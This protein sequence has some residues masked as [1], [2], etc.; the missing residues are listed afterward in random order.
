MIKNFDDDTKHQVHKFWMT[1]PVP[2][3]QYQSLV[4]ESQ[5]Q[6][7][8]INL[9]ILESGPIETKSL[10]EIKK[11]SYKLP[12]SYKWVTLDMTN[13]QDIDDIFILLAEHYVEDS[14]NMFRF[15]YSRDFLKWALMCPN[16]DPAFLVGVRMVN[17]SQKLVSF[18]SGVRINIRIQDRVI[19][20]VEINFLC[21]HKNLRKH[22]LAPVL[23]KEI[24]RIGNLAG[25]WQ[26]VYT[27]GIEL[28]GC[29]TRHRYLHRPLNPKKLIECG[30][31]QLKP[32]MTLSRTIKLHHI[33][34][35]PQI[36]GF[37]PLEHNDVHDACNKLNEYLKQFKIAQCFDENEFTH[38]F[39]AR[40]NVVNTYVVQN[41][42]D[43]QLTDMISFYHIPSTIIGNKRHKTLNAVYL[44]YFFLSDKTSINQL[45]LDGL[46]MAKKLGI[47]VFNALDLMDNKLFFEDLKF[48]VGSGYLHYYFYNWKCIGTQPQDVGIIL[49]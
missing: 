47:D 31:S 40:P 25:I 29:V 44:F 16:K 21:I 34:D 23:I 8:D 43:G 7:S 10:S 12:D 24:T 20:M 9:Q 48:G 11:D 18:I 45:M 32:R 35:E 41:P 22:R 42:L 4:Q 38:W 14:D 15:C 6:S 26:A 49:F 36:P 3:S 33:P 13:D 39:I 1:Q 27:A 17:S 37:R 19:P 2:G 46:I 30:F 5:T 28:P